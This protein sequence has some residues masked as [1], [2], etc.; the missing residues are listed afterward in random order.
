MSLGLFAIVAVLVFAYKQ[1]FK[2]PMGRVQMD[3]FFFK[4]PMFG[5]LAQK[6]ATAG[7]LVRNLVQGH[8]F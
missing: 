5:D 4:M 1:Y 3:G 2:T 7:R 8:R 6:F